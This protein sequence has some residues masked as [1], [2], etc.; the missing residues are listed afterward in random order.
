VKLIKLN[1]AFLLLSVF[2]VCITYQTFT[3]VDFYINRAEIA[4]KYCVNKEKPQLNCKG[5]CHLKKKLTVENKN[6]TDEKQTIQPLSFWL[7]A[8]ELPKQVS[9]TFFHTIKQPLF[10]Y[11]ENNISDYHKPVFVPP[12]FL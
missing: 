4:E 8:V 5:Q 7:F 2:S 12:N 6:E 1:I 10:G 3:V 11:P 9:F